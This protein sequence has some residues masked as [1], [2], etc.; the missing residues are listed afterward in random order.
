MPV[1]VSEGEFLWFRFRQ[2]YY[3][4][5]LA[6]KITRQEGLMDQIRGEHRFS[7]LVLDGGNLVHGKSVA[8]TT[9]KFFQD[10]PTSG[11]SRE[12]L[13]QQLREELGVKRIYV[14]PRQPFDSTGH[15][16]RM[17]R[18]LD[19]TRLL[20]ADYTYEQPWWRRKR[21]RSHDNYILIM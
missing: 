5:K 14:L 13:L 2:G 4:K 12:V 21:L 20:V 16:D 11:K 19:D 7:E 3:G 17:V 8:V 9:E 10:N 6:H 1:Q 15:A 18:F